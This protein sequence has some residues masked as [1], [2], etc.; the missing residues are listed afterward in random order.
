MAKVRFPD[1]PIAD[2]V[3]PAVASALRQI[4]GNTKALITQI[5][6]DEVTFASVAGRVTMAHH[7][8]K[9]PT[10]W[11][12]VDTDGAAT[13]LVSAADRA[14]WTKTAVAFTTSGPGT[15]FRVELK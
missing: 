2:T 5:E 7:L 12:V 13:I 8:G 6:S 10:K 1:V 4:V 3:D 15:T 9:L 11:T 14:L